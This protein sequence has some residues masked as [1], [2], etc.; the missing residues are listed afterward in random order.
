MTGFLEEVYGINNIKQQQHM[1]PLIIAAIGGYFVGDG[2]EESPKFA[3]GGTI[4][5]QYEGKTAEQVW[6]A[7]TKEQKEHFLK[8]HVPYKTDWSSLTYSEL[9]GIAKRELKHH[10][11]EGS[12]A[13]GGRIKD[14]DIIV[15]EKYKLPNGEVIEITRLFEEN[16]SHFVVFN[17][18][19][20]EA[21][22]GEN[23]ASVTALR[24]FLNNW[25]G[26]KIEAVMENG[27]TIT[28]YPTIWY[29]V[30]LKGKHWDECP[31]EKWNSLT[32]KDAVKRAK[33]LSAEKKTEVR[34]STTSGFN[35]QGHYIRANF[36]LGGTIFFRKGNNDRMRSFFEMNKKDYL[37]SHNYLDENDYKEIENTVAKMGLKKDDYS[38]PSLEG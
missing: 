7:W 35:N 32:W 17:R 30:K 9:D 34:L 23:E 16:E 3:K 25:G 20:G 28:K 37:R 2:L 24:I 4:V 10:V 26:K 21:Q 5:N 1:I 27:G 38:A 12:F 31:Q 11:K 13:K 19:G 14:E 6:D 8:D 22:Q 18:S 36:A 33:E 29:A 15:G